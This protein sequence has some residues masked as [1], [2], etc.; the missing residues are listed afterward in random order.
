[1]GDT[2]AAAGEILLDP[3]GA[4][5]EGKALLTAGNTGVKA[6]DVEETEQKYLTS[7]SEREI[8]IW[9]LSLV[10]RVYWKEKKLEEAFALAQ[11]TISIVSKHIDDA[12]ANIANASRPT[13]SSLF[14]LLARIYRY[15]SLVSES[16]PGVALA[17]HGDMIKAHGVT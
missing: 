4:C 5:A 2:I 14:P 13:T 9:L 1:M 8:E 10:V 3:A 12:S 15:R 7:A 17:L 6:M 11:K 16:K